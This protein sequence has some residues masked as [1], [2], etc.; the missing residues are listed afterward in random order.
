MYC[1]YRSWDNIMCERLFRLIEFV[2]FPDWNHLISVILRLDQFSLFQ[3]GQRENI[4]K[5]ID[6]K[7]QIVGVRY[8]VLKDVFELDLSY[9]TE[10]AWFLESAAFASSTFTCVS[11]RAGKSWWSVVGI[12]TTVFCVD[13]KTHFLIWYLYDVIMS[14][15]HKTKSCFR[16][17]KKHHTC[18]EKFAIKM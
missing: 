10:I 13:D 14:M 8:P 1:K 2:M 12:F 9:V 15:K 16:S 11:W 6:N 5:F 7:K 17:K 4:Q 3:L 18:L